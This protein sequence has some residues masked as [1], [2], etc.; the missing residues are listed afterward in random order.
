MKCASWDPGIRYPIV[1]QYKD[2]VKHSGGLSE[3]EH[4]N[5]VIYSLRSSLEHGRLWVLI[6]ISPW[7]EE[8]L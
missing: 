7:I 3:K 8:T 2:T 5:M 6:D 1:L 4:F